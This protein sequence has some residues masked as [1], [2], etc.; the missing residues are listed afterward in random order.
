MIARRRTAAIPW[1]STALTAPAVWCALVASHVVNGLADGKTIALEALATQAAGSG[2]YT[3]LIVSVIA[4]GWNWIAGASREDRL[5][6][7]RTVSNPWWM[8]TE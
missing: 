8:L 2:I 4:V 6:M 1:V 5:P 7:S 3:A